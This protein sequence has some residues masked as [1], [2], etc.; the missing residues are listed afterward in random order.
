MS[1][2]D[3]IIT[4]SGGQYYTVTRPFAD[5]LLEQGYIE[6][7]AGETWYRFVEKKIYSD[8]RKRPVGQTG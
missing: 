3:A 4:C 5:A 1:N 8:D 2:A 6:Q 7:V